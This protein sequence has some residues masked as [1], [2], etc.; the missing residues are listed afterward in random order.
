MSPEQI[1]RFWSLAAQTAPD[2]CWLWQGSHHKD[3]YGNFSGHS[4]G[5]HRVAWKLINGPIPP[6]L[7]VCHRCDV[8]RCVNPS[9]MFLG[10][11]LDNTRDMIAKARQKPPHGERLPQSKLSVEKVRA[12]RASTEPAQMLAARYGVTRLT[13]YGVRQRRSWT[14]VD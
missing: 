6:G 4:G 12:I 11:H 9:H 3:G 10:T 7:L 2:D 14:H 8:R 1:A 13:I 5:A